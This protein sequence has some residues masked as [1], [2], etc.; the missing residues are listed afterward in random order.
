MLFI[1]NKNV[2]EHAEMHEIPYST[3]SG[4][5]IFHTYNTVIKLL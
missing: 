3:H 5:G 1:V 2:Y 4:E